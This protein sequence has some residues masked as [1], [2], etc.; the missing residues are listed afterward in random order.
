MHLTTIPIFLF[1]FSSL[2]PTLSAKKLTPIPRSLDA[3]LVEPPSSSPTP[4]PTPTPHVKHLDLRQV[5]AG[6]GGAGNAAAA[7]A[8]PPAAAPAAPKAP[9]PAPAPAPA[10]APAAAV[11]P[12]D[13]P[14]V[15]AGGAASAT[16]VKSGAIGMGTLTGVIGVV[17]TKDAKSGGAVGNRDGLGVEVLG[18]AVCWAVGILVGGGGWLGVV[19]GG[20][21]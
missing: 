12:T 8:Q 16:P 2:P 18:I 10:A 17:N 4:T 14:T 9:A 1:L 11:D 19:G 15:A 20:G 21:L 13:S 7:P 3:V 5:A 6:V